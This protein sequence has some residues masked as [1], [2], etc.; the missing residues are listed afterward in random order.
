MQKIQERRSF[1]ALRLE[2][3]QGNFLVACR[4]GWRA[5]LCHCQLLQLLHVLLPRLVL[6]SSGATTKHLAA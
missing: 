5:L 2:R 3:G 4:T 1:G 6:A